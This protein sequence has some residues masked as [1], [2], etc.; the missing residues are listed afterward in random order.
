MTADDIN[1]L[2]TKTGH[3]FTTL[4]RGSAL[5]V[6]IEIITSPCFLK[7]ALYTYAGSQGS[8]SAFPSL[9]I[10]STNH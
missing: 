2:G 6:H 4:A 1:R 3:V 8:H 9:F 7:I 10:H 5:S